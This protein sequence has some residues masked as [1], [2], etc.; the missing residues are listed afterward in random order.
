MDAQ[1]CSMHAPVDERIADSNLAKAHHP[2]ATALSTGR[3]SGGAGAPLYSCLTPSVCASVCASTC[4][5]HQHAP[6]HKDSNTQQ[7]TSRERGKSAKTKDTER[8]NK[9]RTDTHQHI[10]S[11]Q[12]HAR[13]DTERAE[14]R[15]NRYRAAY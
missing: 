7:Q 2:G 11:A 13:T 10:P 9:A 4:A 8:P 14:T 12:R 15:T 3:R 5:C 6:T 1:R